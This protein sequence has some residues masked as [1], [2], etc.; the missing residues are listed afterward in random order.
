V[1]SLWQI[2]LNAH[3]LKHFSESRHRNFFPWLRYVAEWT[4]FK[5]PIGRLTIHNFFTKT[6]TLLQSYVVAYRHKTTS[7]RCQ[8]NP[9]H[10]TIKY[11]HFTTI[12]ASMTWWSEQ[13]LLSRILIKFVKRFFSPFALF[14][15]SMI[16]SLIPSSLQYFIKY[17]KYCALSALKNSFYRR[18]F[19]VDTECCIR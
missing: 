3:K 4:G 9:A 10:T 2:P 13:S 1:F 14:A 8:V 11:L 18:I 19:C 7:I 17:M 6:L 16:F 5:R 15:L 12:L